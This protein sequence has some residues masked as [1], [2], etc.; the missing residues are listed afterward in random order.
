MPLSTIFQLY[1]GSQFY[2]W[3]KPEKTID[4]SQVTDKL[5]HMLYRIHLAMNG[6]QTHNVSGDRHWLHRFCCKFNCHTITATTAPCFKEK[7]QV[8][9][10][11]TSS[12]NATNFNRLN[13]EYVC[14]CIILFFFLLQ[15]PARFPRARFF[16]RVCDYHMD[17]VDDVRRHGKDHRHQRR[18]DVSKDTEAIPLW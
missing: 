5:Y 3:R 17:T 8:Y 7:G 6:V 12:S 4:L 2:W 13:T 15:K 1:R 16:C 10:Y 9:C 18:V 14:F 11:I